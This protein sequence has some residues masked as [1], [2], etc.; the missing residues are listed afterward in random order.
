MAMKWNTHPIEF[1]KAR[2]LGATITGV[3]ADSFAHGNHMID[4]L[5]ITTKEGEELMITAQ[6]YCGDE[7][8]LIIEDSSEWIGEEAE[9]T[10]KL[11]RARIKEQDREIAK[12]QKKIGMV[13]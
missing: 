10:I 3:Y 6:S 5:I 1:D 8:G 13:F 11:L 12:L 7:N 4:R 2:L 9:N